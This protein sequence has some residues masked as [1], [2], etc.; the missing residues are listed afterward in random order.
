MSTLALG[1]MTRHVERGNT[2]LMPV[3]QLCRVSVS[4]HFLQGG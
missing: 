1:I 4:I 3:P 2:P